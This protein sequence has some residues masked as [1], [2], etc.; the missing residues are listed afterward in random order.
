MV[1]LLA[2]PL[3]AP[4]S[5]Q[6]C[7]DPEGKAWPVEGRQQAGG[8]GIISRIYK[9]PKRPKLSLVIRGFC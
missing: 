2:L 9:L 6:V 8:T 4:W 7:A 3:A 5:F 1:I